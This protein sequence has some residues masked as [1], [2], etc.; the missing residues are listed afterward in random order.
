MVAASELETGQGGDQD[1]AVARQR[2]SGSSRQIR[3]A[4][5]QAEGGELCC[6]QREEWRVAGGDV[7]GRERWRG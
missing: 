3:R 6:R 1:L 4:T 5:W 7:G 2:D